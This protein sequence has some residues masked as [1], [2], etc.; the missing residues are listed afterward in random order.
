MRTR[1]MNSDCATIRILRM[2]AFCPSGFAIRTK[3]SCSDGRVTSKWYTAA[4]AVRRD[5]KSLGI[6]GH[7]HFLQLAEIVDGFDFR[8]AVE[9]CRPARGADAHG[10]GAVLRSGCSRA[11]RRAPCGRGRS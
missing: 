2:A 10:I 3:M 6:A 1:V 11:S 8:H 9:R 5:E 4:R 7:P